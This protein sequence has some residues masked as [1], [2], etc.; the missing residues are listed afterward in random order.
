MMLIQSPYASSISS[1]PSV[2]SS[3]GCSSDGGASFTTGLQLKNYAPSEYHVGP[4]RPLSEKLTE[5]DI[6][7]EGANSSGRNTPVDALDGAAERDTETPRQGQGVAVYPPEPGRQPSRGDAAPS[8]TP[9]AITSQGPAVSQPG[10]ASVQMAHS[11]SGAHVSTTGARSG[12]V[13]SAWKSSGGLSCQSASSR[14][15]SVDLTSSSVN[16]VDLTCHPVPYPYSVE[17]GGGHSI[18]PMSVDSTSH[19]SSTMG[20]NSYTCRP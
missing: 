20:C 4:R 3:S 13:D 19:V 15:N 17:S 8:F 1:C 14:V 11:R 12:P 10:T 16:S 5:E 9:F 6:V 2:S 7:S 18:H